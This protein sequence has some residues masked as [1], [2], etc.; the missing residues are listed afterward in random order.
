MRLLVGTQNKGKIKEYQL[1]LAEAPVEV[2]GLADIGLGTL[3]VDETGTT[4]SENAILKA[5]AYADASGLPTLAD[6]SGLCVDALDGR[7]G[8]YSARYGGEGLDNAGKRKKLL[9]EL[10]DVPEDKRGAQFLAHINAAF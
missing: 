9:G 6:D 8:L 3:D 1:L 2:V 5:R 4:F 7:P 10:T